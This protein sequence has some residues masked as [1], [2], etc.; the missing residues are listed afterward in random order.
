MTLLDGTKRDKSTVA[1][2]SIIV[3][4]VGT[5]CGLCGVWS[6]ARALLESSCF[7]SSFDFSFFGS[8]WLLEVVDSD[9]FVILLEDS[10]LDSLLE[11]V[12]LSLDSV[13]VDSLLESLLSSVDPVVSP[14]CSTCSVVSCMDRLSCANT[15]N[16]VERNACKLSISAEAM[17][18]NFFI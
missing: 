16:G 8:S 10:E 3:C 15:V 5:S 13:V 6:T 2:W 14:D 7:V 1:S 17:V 12:L 18:E 9:G 11:V 4:G